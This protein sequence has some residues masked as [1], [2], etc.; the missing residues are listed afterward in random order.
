MGGDNWVER[1]SLH[2]EF[3]FS[4]FGFPLV[5]TLFVPHFLVFSLWHHHRLESWFEIFGHS[6][7]FPFGFSHTYFLL[8]IPIDCGKGEGACIYG[9]IFFAI[10][11]S[12]TPVNISLLLLA[13]Y[14]VFFTYLRFVVLVSV[15]TFGCT[16]KI[17]P[18]I[19]LIT[20]K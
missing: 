13:C 3:W 9:H 15:Y 19:S 2:L 5:Y 1:F 18:T 16:N 8:Y 12:S 10:L 7:F 20:S 6:F 14:L 17:S 4:F 11:F